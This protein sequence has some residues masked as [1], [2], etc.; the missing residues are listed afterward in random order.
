VFVLNYV[1][2]CLFENIYLIPCRSCSTLKKGLKTRCIL[3]FRYVRPI[4]IVEEISIFISY[5]FEP[6]L[7]TRINRVSRHDD[8]G[9]MPSSENLSI[10]SNLGRPAQKNTVSRR[11]LSKIKF[12]QT[13]NY[14]LFNYDEL[15]ILFSKYIYY[16]NFIING[17]FI[18]CNIIN[19]YIVEYLDHRQH[20]QYLMSNNSQLIESQIF[21]L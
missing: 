18:S 5:Y 20:C 8:G 4:Y 6:H 9:E 13:H 21:R 17:L 19:S 1:C 7:R 2:F 10:F 11:Y 14:M 12:R 16:F 3:R 15:D